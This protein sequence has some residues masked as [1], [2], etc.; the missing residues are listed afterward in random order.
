MALGFLHVS[1]RNTF[2]DENEKCYIF[3]EPI[4]CEIID[5]ANNS[6]KFK[7]IK[8]LFIDFP[9]LKIY[10]VDNS[11]IVES[12]GSVC[13]IPD[14]IEYDGI[15]YNGTFKTSVNGTETDITFGLEIEI[16]DGKPIAIIAFS[17]E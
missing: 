11:T 13:L 14:Y 1:E 16:N 3:K 6:V 10:D 17:I 7:T 9:K 2:F 5:A 8:P 4:N 15:S 12:E